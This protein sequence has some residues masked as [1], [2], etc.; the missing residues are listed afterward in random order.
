MPRVAVVDIG[1]FTSR[2]AVAEVADGRVVDLEK[3]TKITDLGQGVAQSGRLAPEAIGRV[4][5]CVESYAKAA[6]AS[7]VEA[8]VTTLTSAARDAENAEELLDQLRALGLE[9]QVIP[10][11]VEGSLTFLGVAQDAP[12]E[13]IL[14]AD[15]GGGS[16]E[17]AL[18]SLEGGVLNVRSLNIGCRRITDLFLSRNDPPTAAD[19]AE[20]RAW[21]AEQFAPHAEELRGLTSASR[22]FVVGGTAT[23]LVAIHLGLVPYDGSRVH[24][25]DF[26]LSDTDALAEKLLSLTL[27]ERAA[28]PG[29]QAKRASVIAGGALVLSEL[30]RTFGFASMVVSEHD[31]LYGLAAAA[32]AACEGKQALPGWNPVLS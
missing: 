26:A 6:R 17:L 23:S 13:T 29:L 12:K 15:S 1:T 22:L 30:M 28:T 14:V 3:R 25:Y 31:L 9:P 32:G 4:V 8:C 7:G 11:E 18:G 20:A 5:E 19:V 16:T 10:G 21:A 27:N 24:L 2:L